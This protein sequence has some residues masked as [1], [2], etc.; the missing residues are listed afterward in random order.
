MK[1]RPLSNRSLTFENLDRRIL[2][3]GDCID[4][5][6]AVEDQPQNAVAAQFE[7]HHTPRLQLGDAPLAGTPNYD[8]S[9]QAEIVWLTIP[10][11]EG[12]DDSF[13]VEFRAANSETWKTAPLNEQID[14]QTNGRIV[15]SAILSDLNWD[16]DY[17]YRV[18]H[19]RDAEVIDQYQAEFRTRL[20]AGDQRGFSYAAYGDSSTF[21]SIE[22]FRSVQSRINQENLDFAIL[23]GDN[24]YNRGSHS[25]SDGRFQAELN[26]EAV[27]W[28]RSKIDYFGIGNN[29]MFTNNGQPSRDL[30]SVPI[31]TAQN[32][33]AQPP[34]EEFREHNY[35]FDYGNTHFLTLD[36]NPVESRD[37]A[38]RE[39]RVNA[40]MDY[41]L[42]D[43]AAS[44]AQWKVVF[45]HHPFIGTEKHQIDDLYR[46]RVLTGLKDAGVDLYLTSHSHS[47]SWTYPLSGFEDTDQDGNI[48]I[49]EVTFVADLDRSYEKGAGIIQVV[50]G[51]G[52][53]TLRS[54]TYDEP[55][56]VAGYSRATSTGPLVYGYSRIDVTPRSLSVSYISAE[57][58]QIVGDTN[59]NGVADDDEPYF[60]KF[61]IVDSSMPSPDLNEDGSLGEADID[62]LQAAIRNREN[63]ARFDLD[64]DQ[65]VSGGDLDLLIAG[66]FDTTV[67]DS[68]LDG[69]FDSKD[70]VEIFQAAEFEDTESLNST[71]A[72]G[73]W[74]GDGDFTTRDL[75]LAFQVGAYISGE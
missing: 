5:E 62:L 18:T 35:S 13:V 49:D 26:P 25:A 74:D 73:D 48:H 33:F 58:G 1:R 43:L 37:L 3:H 70:L 20:E 27:E 11:G 30:F 75:V 10:A 4:C 47:Y 61:E 19:L 36:M 29:E 2:L 16:S 31:P 41:A 28:N 52:G 60:G 71:W 68:N 67:G 63:D 53:G 9:D 40:L 24:I 6:V 22:N 64:R 46:A 38:E 51:A 66:Y 17:V 7:V 21:N 65:D 45:L 12:T 69:V 42:A 44:D 34:D 72:E 8:G 14:T 39:R 15:H 55:I 57:T 54:T 56:F 50:S 23:L 32:S 59:G